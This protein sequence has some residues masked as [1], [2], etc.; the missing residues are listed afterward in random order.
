MLNHGF[1]AKFGFGS[2]LFI[3]TSIGTLNTCIGIFGSFPRVKA[4][5]YLLILPE[6]ELPPVFRLPTSGVHATCFSIC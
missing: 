6:S 5:R 3:N 1:V 2:L 4:Q